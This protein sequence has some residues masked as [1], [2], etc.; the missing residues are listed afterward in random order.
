LKESDLIELN[1]ENVGKILVQC[2]F[3]SD[4]EIESHLIQDKQEQR[5]INEAGLRKDS[6]NE[7]SARQSNL[8]KIPGLA[9][10]SGAF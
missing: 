7:S 10:I 4:R 3:I 2:E 1:I 9:A 5:S 6:I 8:F